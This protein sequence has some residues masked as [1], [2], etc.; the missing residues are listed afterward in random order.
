MRLRLGASA[1]AVGSVL[2]LLAVAAVGAQQP[3]TFKSSVDLV[4]LD[5]TVVDGQGRP[6]DD[7]A[8]DEFEVR[9]NGIVTPVAALRFLE[10]GT[11]TPA[12]A[13]GTAMASANGASPGGRIIVLAVDEVSLPRA[14]SA[15][16][17][18]ETLAAWIE[19]LTPA[20]RMSIEALPKPGLRQKLTS[21]KPA[22][23]RTV[24]KLRARPPAMPERPGLSGYGGNSPAPSGGNTYERAGGH[25]TFIGPEDFSMASDQG[26]LLV[27]VEDLVRSL[28]SMDG[29]KTL[30]LVS[31]GL[32][33]DSGLLSRY[34][35]I[36]ALANEARVRVYVLQPH[37]GKGNVSGNRSEQQTD[38]RGA[39]S[40]G[41][42]F[43]AGLTGGAV[44]HAVARA[45]GVVDR[46]ERETTGLYVVGLELPAGSPRNTRLDV[47]VKVRR[48]G[49]TVRSPHQVVTPAK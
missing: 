30:V 5:V 49:V 6:I 22:L 37:L 42:H 15:R 47:T 39:A 19:R 18:M 40:D 36:A 7:L 11:L 33:F 29:P 23:K 27:A 13:L 32:G 38:N 35:T 24:Y 45:E 16:P 25:P 21:D 12:T 1:R 14:D 10:F 2:V 28:T 31:A 44:F 46:I 4:R 20:D 9:I 48:E 17:L 26:M 43:L 41:S 34:H 8:P 3:P